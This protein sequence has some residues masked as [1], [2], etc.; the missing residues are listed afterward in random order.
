MVQASH[1]TL[2]KIYAKM[3]GTNNHKEKSV[4]K[5]NIF[6]LIC[7]SLML[8]SPTWAGSD[9]DLI[10]TLITDQAKAFSDFPRSRDKQAVL[11]FF[12]QDYSSVT[13]GQVGNLKD[14][15]KDLSDFEKQINL[16][17]PLNISDRV[18]NINVQVSGVL[19]W[20]TFNDE[21]KISVMDK[22]VVDEQGKCTGIYQKKGTQ[23]L[24]QHE[25]C[26]TPTDKDTQDGL[27]RSGAN[28]QGLFTSKF[29]VRL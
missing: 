8:Y 14:M 7:F 17:N 27:T 9:E 10:R 2:L 13:D 28:S 12:S 5:L 11:K 24:I 21:V 6:I 22:T 18:S 23:W 4:N 19:A 20:A 1:Q 15:E 16:G 29:V 3:S 25:H 26:S